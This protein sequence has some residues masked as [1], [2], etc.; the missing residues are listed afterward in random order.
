MYF[1]KNLCFSLLF[2]K[3]SVAQVPITP[4]EDPTIVCP[5]TD[6][7]TVSVNGF[8]ASPFKIT[9]FVDTFTNPPRAVSKDKVCRTDGH[10][11]FS[12]D[13]SIFAAQ[14]RPFDNIIPGCKA[15]PGTWFMTYNGSVPGP[16]IRVPSGHESLVRF[17]NLI[18][19]I[20]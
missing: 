8:T 2:V 17:K 18:N 14:K 4:F 20:K 11:L 10:C 9:P 3:I 5:N 6:G 19:N 16:T 1:V 12:Y 13:I 15:L 7:T